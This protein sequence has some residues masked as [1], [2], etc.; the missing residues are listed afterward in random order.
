ML[1]IS[2]NDLIKLIA[3]SQ[4]KNTTFGMFQNQQLSFFPN[5]V[6]Y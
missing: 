6:I 5:L 1:P 2:T 4:E 3:E